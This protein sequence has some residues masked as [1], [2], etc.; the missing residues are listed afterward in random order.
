MGQGIV[1]YHIVFC[2]VWRH[3]EQR[4][5]TLFYSLL[6]HTCIV[7]VMCSKYNAETS[8]DGTVCKQCSAVCQIVNPAD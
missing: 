7:F 1:L 5:R 6:Y 2:C 8:K 3:L 4:N